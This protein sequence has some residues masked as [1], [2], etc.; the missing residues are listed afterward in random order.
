MGYALRLCHAH[1]AGDPE[2]AAESRVKRLA[3]RERP[4]QIAT[5]MALTMP[6]AQQHT[7]PIALASQ[8]AQLVKRWNLSADDLLSG[9]GLGRAHIEDPS[10]RLPVATMSA[11]LERARDLTGEPGLGYYLGLQTRATLY[12]YL[13][14]AALSAASLGDAL[15]LAVEYAPI[16]STALAIDLSVNGGLA[17]IRLEERAD[18]GS[19]R[20]IVLISMTLGLREMGQ[21]LTGRQLDGSAEL[22]IPEPDYQA[23]FAH[24]VPR[25]RFGQPEN[26]ILFDA[27][28][29]DLP[30][31]MADPIA[32]RLAQQQCERELDHLGFDTRLA[33][34]VRRLVAGDEGARRSMEQ[35]AACLDMSP[36]TLR[37]RLVEQGVSFAELVDHERRNRALD[38][39]RSSRLS[40]QDIA[41]RLEYRT[42]S[43]FVRAFHRWTGETPATYRRGMRV[44]SH[45]GAGG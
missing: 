14:F 31:V 16:F 17:C 28:A 11:L 35:V 13:G 23:R 12:G 7:V 20:D 1:L 37:R 15:A 29:I 38:L 32:L 30:V 6:L 5:T 39:L 8:L 2:R 25:V 45:S 43:S 34:R 4:C 3:S 9:V 27:A 42:A 22:A 26:R 36:R 40:I 18:L 44:R 41:T 19:V 21:A 24:L 33:A 10:G